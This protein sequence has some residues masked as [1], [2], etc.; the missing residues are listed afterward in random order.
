MPDLRFEI[1]VE[2]LISKLGE[3]NKA[4]KG[5]VVAAFKGLAKATHAKAEE[6]ARQDLGSLRETYQD[7]L[8]FDEIS[9]HF[10]VVTLHEP[11]MWIEEYGR[12]AGFMED[13][14]TTEKPGSQGKI[15]DGKNGKYRV[16]PFKHST[17]PSQQSTKANELANQIKQVLRNRKINWKKIEVNADKS[18]RVG[19]RV[20]VDGEYIDKPLLLHRFN[21]EGPRFS[22]PTKGGE[23]KGPLTHG[24]AIYQTAIRDKSGKVTGA[25][26]DIMTFRVISE[27]HKAEGLWYHPGIQP[28]K[29]LDKA[30]DWAVRYWESDI[31][32]NIISKYQ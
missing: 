6:L 20:K 26:R 1:D 3:V 16:I 28:V 32:P 24:V 11:A 7:N 31:L 5:D 17:K 23:H 25:S 14:L 29:I 30:F 8:D 13:L 21:V 19:P 15:K 2:D 4:I 27:K 10:W 22:N 9:P 12:K 18:P